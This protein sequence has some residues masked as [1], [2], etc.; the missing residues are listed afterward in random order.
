MKFSFIMVSYNEVEYLE[1][2]ISSCMSQKLDDYEIVIGDD[3]SND[4]SIDLIKKYAEMYPEIVRYSVSDRTGIGSV[5]DII[6]SLRVS[7]VIARS[8]DMAK[9]EYCV[10]LSGDDYFYETDFFKNAIEFLDKNPDYV[11]YVGGY[12]KV[13][14]D[15]PAIADYIIYPQK[16]YWA[17]KYVHLS[18]FVF[19]KSVY[20]QG[21][22][23]QRFCDDTGLQYSLAFSGKWKCEK[24][25]M[26][27]YRQRSGSIMHTA[28]PLQNYVVELMIFQD[29]LCKGFLY[30]QSLA[31]YGKS[32]RYVFQHREEL[33][34]EKY[35]KYLLNC[36]KYENNILDKIYNYDNLS[37]SE[38]VRFNGCLICS[39]IL[40][41]YY[42][43]IGRAL[44]LENKL[45]NR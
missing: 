11:S 16:I 35:Q 26:F 28:N 15:R 14:E 8:L 21:A 19:R 25:I 3:G 4:G 5:K 42:K 40:E 12:E 39:Y 10:V 30:H 41:I 13:W 33:K 31:K 29:V 44:N 7:K 22:F 17:R 38:K 34:E 36:K 18:S 6:A 1:Q 27:A 24:T 20:D 2:A 37:K 23:L 32:L 45:E 43:I 9:G